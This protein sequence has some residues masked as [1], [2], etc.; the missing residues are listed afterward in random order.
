MV[1]K[2]KAKE[3]QS[4]DHPDPKLR[5]G[6]RC[7][8]LRSPWHMQHVVSRIVRSYRARLGLNSRCMLLMEQHDCSVHDLTCFSFL[9]DLKPFL[10]ISWPNII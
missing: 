10:F 1:S 6:I 2:K 7:G 8:I 4:E 9:E 5:L 3:S